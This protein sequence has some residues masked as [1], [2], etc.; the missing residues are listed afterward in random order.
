MVERHGAYA[1]AFC[2]QAAKMAGDGHTTVYAAKKSGG[3]AL[4]ML[5]HTR[6]HQTPD[7]VLKIHSKQ[8]QGGA[9]LRC[10]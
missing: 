9:C 5:H 8:A 10:I 6:P 2:G 1:A 4:F 3:G 7:F